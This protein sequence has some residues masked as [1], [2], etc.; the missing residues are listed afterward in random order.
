MTGETMGTRYSITFHESTSALAGAVSKFGGQ[1]FWLKEPQWPSSRETGHP[2]RFI[3]Q[4]AL[5]ETLFPGGPLRMAYLFMTDEEKYVDGTWE[6]EGG[7]NAV[8]VQTA[9]SPENVG[10]QEVLGPSLYRMVQKPGADRLTPEPCEFAVVLTR[11]NDPVFQPEEARLPAEGASDSNAYVEAIAGNKVGGTPMFIQSDE[12]PEGGPWLL[13][14]QLDS[15]QVPFSV[16]FG[17][18]GVGY[19]FVSEDGTAARFLWQC[20]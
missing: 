11:A 1:P 4:V 6:P 16:N 2:M 18:A 8:V 12:F 10:Q 13:M 20:A 14:L 3:G 9:E 7:E 5:H 19:A 17:D 15:T